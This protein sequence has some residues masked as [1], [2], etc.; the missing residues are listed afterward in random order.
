[1]STTA[2]HNDTRFQGKSIV[3]TGAGGNFGR[4]GCLYFAA[5][6]CKVAALDKNPTALAET[7]QEVRAKY[8]KAIICSATCDVTNAANVQKVVDQV[9]KNWEVRSISCGIMLVTKEKFNLLS[10]TIP[11]ILRWS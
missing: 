1:M 3:I 5:R 8:P 7:V 4:E 9:V 6:G 10:S 11:M 2:T